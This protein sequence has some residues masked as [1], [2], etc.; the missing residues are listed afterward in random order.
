MTSESKRAVAPDLSEDE[1][2]NLISLTARQVVAFEKLRKAFDD[3]KKENI[4][5]YQRVGRLT[6]LNG[7]NVKG[8][9]TDDDEYL[10][11]TPENIVGNHKRCLNFIILP[12]PI[13]T[14]NEYADDNHYVQFKTDKNG[15]E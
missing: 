12:P 1:I 3:C 8:I 5:L 2:Y 11:S 4:L 9:H 13:K 6:A 10:S 14:A 7:N 15:N